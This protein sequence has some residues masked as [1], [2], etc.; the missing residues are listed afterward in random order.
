MNVSAKVILA[1]VYFVALTGLLHGCGSGGS[2]S[3]P[4]AP[5]GRL[6]QGPVVNATVFAD[7]VGGGARFVLDA[8]EVN[9]ATD[10][11]TGDFV[12]PAT[13]GYNYILVSKGGTDRLTG[14]AAMQMIAPAGA[15]NITPLTTLVALDTSGTVKA[16]LQALMPTGA[17]YDAD[18]STTASQAVLLVAKS[19]E[20]MVQTM[21][22]AMVTKAGAGAITDRQMAVLQ[23]QTMQAIAVQFANPAVD[24]ATLTT[25]ATLSTALQSAATA[26]ATSIGSSNAN[27]VM[28]G[29]TAATIASS[30]VTATAGALGIGATASTSTIVGGESAVINQQAAQAFGT[31]VQSQ[32]AA[33]AT[34]ITAAA[35][36]TNYTA[37][38]IQVVTQVTV[39][40]TTGTTGGN[41]GGTGVTF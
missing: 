25:P 8:G 9:T 30:S 29:A 13:P 1:G 20:T 12:L 32:A 6:V 35:T 31:A 11:V 15:S 39:P 3:S 7:N 36:P 23:A 2:G 5:S 41:T 16:K 28:P 17:S 21:T 26:A 27:I 37:P 24:Q 10:S 18:I 22:Q 34:T 40:G 14:Q 38:T 33:A 19:V 4:S